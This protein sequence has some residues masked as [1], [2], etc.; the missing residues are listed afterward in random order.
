LG[1]RI[2]DWDRDPDSSNGIFYGGLAAGKYREVPGI[3]ADEPADDLTVVVYLTPDIPFGYGTSLWQH[4]KTGLMNAPTSRDAR[5]LQTSLARIR[6]SLER[7]TAKRS[8]WIEIDRVGYR[9]NRM[10]AYASGM[11]HS[12][13]RHFGA[14][15]RGGRVYQTF[16]LGVDWRSA[17]FQA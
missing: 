6:A 3:H 15:V 1:I 8:R 12:A 16:R 17:Q 9:Y 2:T 14:D 7:D 13:T 10:V 5:R 4:R 11:F